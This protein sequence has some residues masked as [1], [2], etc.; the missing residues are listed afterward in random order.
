MTLLCRHVTREIEKAGYLPESTVDE[1]I[2]N[3]GCCMS[4]EEG[5]KA[6]EAIVR[7]CHLFLVPYGRTRNWY[8]SRPKYYGWL[9]EQKASA[10]TAKAF[11]DLKE[12]FAALG[13][14]KDCAALAEECGRQ[15]EI[16]KEKEKAKKLER[17]KAQEAQ[18]KKNARRRFWRKLFPSFSRK[19]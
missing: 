10:K 16:F 4:D 1:Y 2:L 9:C 17:Q 14:F 13:D 18:E 7:E 19:K 8:Y 11:R 15:A 3:S 12:K 5:K 6:L